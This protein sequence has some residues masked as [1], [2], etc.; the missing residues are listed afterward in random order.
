MQ[1]ALFYYKIGVRV[2]ESGDKWLKVVNFQPKSIEMI[3]AI[4][5]RPLMC[6]SCTEDAMRADKC[7]GR[8]IDDVYGRI[9]SHNRHKGQADHSFKIQRSV[10]RYLR[11]DKGI[12]WLP[13][14]V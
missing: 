9:Q 1:Y 10:G 11:G 2:V 13:I 5:G 4:R 12:G 14:C 8:V 3:T 7:S 6:E